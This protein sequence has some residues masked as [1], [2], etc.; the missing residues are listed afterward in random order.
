MILLSYINKKLEKVLNNY[1][2]VEV[3]NITNRIVNQ[4]ILGNN[5]KGK[6]LI[7][8]RNNNISY[9][10]DLINN[11]VDMISDKI[12]KEIYNI[13]DISKN[14][15]I[16]KSNN[17]YK[18]IHN[19]VICNI[20]LSSIRNSVLFASLGTSIP[21]K[22]TFLGSVNSDVNIETFEYGINNILVKL[23]LKVNVKMRVSLPFTSKEQLVSVEQPLAIDI[24]KGEIPEYY[25]TS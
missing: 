6:Y 2:D 4:V 12:E 16:F 24:I 9:N 20:M 25:K 22:L 19:G 5:F 13:D 11:Y 14:S 23:I 3:A 21:V 15:D 17:K 10:T 7:T 8:D 1:I 18:H